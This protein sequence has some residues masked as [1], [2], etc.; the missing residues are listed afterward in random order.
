MKKILTILFRARRNTYLIILACTAVFISSCDKQSIEPSAATQA[1]S[2]QVENALVARTKPAPGN[3]SVAL[4]VN[5][6][7]TSTMDFDGYVFN[8]QANGTLTAK[9]DKATYTGKWES[10]EDNKGKGKNN[11]IEL[12]LDIDGTNALHKIDKSWNVIKITNSLIN[13]NDPEHGI[14]GRDRLVFTRL[15]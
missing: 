13:L 3:Y 5:D 7:D 11:G 15:N 6:G 1:N 10:K 4:F 14:N 8:F 2:S 12:K 9:V